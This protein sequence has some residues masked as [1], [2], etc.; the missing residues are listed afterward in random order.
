MSGLF[1]AASQCCVPA[2]CARAANVQAPRGSSSMFWGCPSCS[3]DP[4][5]VAR[6]R[7]AWAWRIECIHKT[8]F[9]LTGE[10][11]ISYGWVFSRLGHVTHQ[12]CPL[13]RHSCP[14]SGLHVIHL[15]D[16][17]GDPSVFHSSVSLLQERLTWSVTQISCQLPNW[18]KFT[19]LYHVKGKLVYGVFE[20]YK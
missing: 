13:K 8:A 20:S 5:K 3:L 17:C 1:V 19:K 10:T 18:L 9:F 11:P 12:V 7:F 16:R 2:T 15:W 14:A 6:P 4:V